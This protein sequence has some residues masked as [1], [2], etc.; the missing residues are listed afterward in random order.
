MRIFIVSD[1]A[2]ISMR[3]RQV[4]LSRGED[5]PA[6]HLVPLDQV[7]PR[8]GRT[9]ADLL[10]LV[11]PHD[12]E[13]ALAALAEL[14]LVTPA[15]VLVVGPASDSRLVLRALRAGASD[16]ME[17]GELEAELPAALGRLTAGLPS[18]AEPGRIVGV[19]AP[20]GGSGSSTVA[21]NLATAL[22]GKHGNVLLCD[23]KLNTGDL[24]SLLDVKP[25]HTL[26][27]LCMGATRMDRSMFE[28]SLVRHASGVQL[29]APP[30]SFSEVRL[31]TVEG[32]RQALALGRALFPHVVVDLD[33]SFGDEQLEVLRQADVI[34]LVMRL[35][36]TSLRHAQRTLE[37][38]RDLGLSRDRVHVVV[39]RFGQ[40]QE[41][42]FTKA[43]EALGLKIAHYVP[44]DPK[45]VNR[46]N[47][48]GV[49]VVLENASCK[50]SRSLVQLATILNGKQQ[51]S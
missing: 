51:P 19:L 41:V 46:A 11:M 8:L 47:N 29:L 38:L 4:L 25:T 50:V 31:V 39:N 40:P 10:V 34:L 1:N 35:D 37:Y 20:S 9:P 12:P 44:D 14:H 15:R 49:P 48:N 28:R 6:G 26:A 13:R 23:F 42:P 36:F 21:V 33:H 24:A 16:Y 30:R 3:V 2:P 32:V 27:D 18:R 45:T 17:E 7:V 5:C 22:A 43:E